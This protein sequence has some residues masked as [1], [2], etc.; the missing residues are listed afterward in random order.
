M[1]IELAKNEVEVI[2]VPKVPILFTI[3]FGNIN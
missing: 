1:I 2:I 3:D